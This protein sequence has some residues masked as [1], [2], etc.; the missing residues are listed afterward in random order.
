MGLTRGT[1]VSTERLIVRYSCTWD[2]V[3]IRIVMRMEIMANA[4]Q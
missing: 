3:T 2:S 4:T 1:L